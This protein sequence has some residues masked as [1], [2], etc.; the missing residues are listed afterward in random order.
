[1]TLVY[2][3]QLGGGEFQEVLRAKSEMSR[4]LAIACEFLT[5]QSARETMVVTFL[6]LLASFKFEGCSSG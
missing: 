1:M 3:I 6:T 2:I 5:D 4:P